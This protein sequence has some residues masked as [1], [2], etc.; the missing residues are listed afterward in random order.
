MNEIIK[1]MA[2][3]SEAIQE[4]FEEQGEKITAHMAE[5]VYFYKTV[6]RNLGTAGTQVV[7]GFPFIPELLLIDVISVGTRKISFGKS[8]KDGQDYAI[9]KIQDLCWSRQN[10]EAIRIY[11]DSTRITTGKVT[12]NNNGTINILWEFA[13]A[14]GATGNAAVHITAIGHRRGSD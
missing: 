3:A 11:E 10:G 9:Y 12:I 6:S 7:D 1:G 5:S 13:A 8:F 4:N 2:N 14:E